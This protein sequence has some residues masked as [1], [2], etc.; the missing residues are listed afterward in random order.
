MGGAYC[1]VD[2]T[3]LAQFFD[4]CGY[5]CLLHLEVCFAQNTSHLTNESLALV[6]TQLVI[7]VAKV[8]G[9]SIVIFMIMS[10]ILA[11][12]INSASFCD[13]HGTIDPTVNCTYDLIHATS[14]FN[15]HLLR[16][17]GWGE[18]EGIRG[19]TCVR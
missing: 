19:T 4:G 9:Y 15:T 8:S 10:N 12:S 1:H 2:H 14:T 13:E 18:G 5:Q 11:T 6:K 17:R 7:L 3:M 16:G